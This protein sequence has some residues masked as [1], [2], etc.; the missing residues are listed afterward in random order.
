MGTGMIFAAES[1]V[2]APEGESDT[3]VS[4]DVSDFTYTSSTALAQGKGDKGDLI[5][6]GADVPVEPL[7]TSLYYNDTNVTTRNAANYIYDADWN[8][9]NEFI[10]NNFTVAVTGNIGTE[11]TNQQL[12]INVSVTPFTQVDGGVK[13]SPVEIVTANNYDNNTIDN[14]TTD[15][16]LLNPV[17]TADAQV[18]TKT[19]A[20]D[21]RYFYK[22]YSSTYSDSTEANATTGQIPGN[23]FR[24]QIK[25]TGTEANL[26]SGRYQSTVTFTYSLD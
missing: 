9:S 26:P 23:V 18:T 22:G 1:A 14:V 16:T 24:F 8:A 4:S 20:L 11:E 3:Y 7:T 5:V 10:T 25:N 12:K 13:A 19:N 6:V 21:S 17:D 2:T 15:A